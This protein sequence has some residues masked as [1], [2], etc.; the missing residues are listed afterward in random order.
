MTMISNLPDIIF[1]CGFMGSGKSTIGRGLADSLEWP[2]LDLDDKI[3]EIAGQEIPEIF[4][5]EGEAGFRTIERRALLEVARKFKGVVAL[6]GGSLQ[7]QHMVDHLKLKGLLIFLE[8]P[9]SVILGRV[10]GDENRPLLLDKRGNPKNKKVLEQDLQALY[11]ERLPFY[12]Q[13][14]INVANDGSKSP[15]Q[16]VEILLK[17]I[18]NHVEDY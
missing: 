1:L 8:T 18:R 17:K 9:I 12:K 4:E 14:V 11:D 15:E 3:E 2:F 6:G 10:S 7:S 16:I 13:A 5:R